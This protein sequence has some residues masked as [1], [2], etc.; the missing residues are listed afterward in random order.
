MLNYAT[1]HNIPVPPSVHPKD[2]REA[3]AQ[4]M[5]QKAG[6]KPWKSGEQAS[7]RTISW[8]DKAKQAVSAFLASVPDILRVNYV[9]FYRVKRAI[10]EAGEASNY[11]AAKVQVISLGNEIIT[12]N[13]EIPH[14]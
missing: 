1:R 14:A 8:E 4:W 6:L 11:F 13:V 2:A 12:L 5:I 7:R 9:G 3:V 10:Q